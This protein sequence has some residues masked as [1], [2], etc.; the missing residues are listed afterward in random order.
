MERR[1]IGVPIDRRHRCINGFVLYLLFYPVFI[2]TVFARHWVQTDDG[3][4]FETS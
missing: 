4:A 3:P 2:G 1:E